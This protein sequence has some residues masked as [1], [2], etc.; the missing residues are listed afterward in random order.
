MLQPA[1]GYDPAGGVPPGCVEVSPGCVAEISPAIVVVSLENVVGASPG[2]VAEVSPAIVVAV[3]RG[4]DLVLCMH[5]L[6]AGNVA[7]AL[8]RLEHVS[9]LLPPQLSQLS[10][11]FYLP[12]GRLSHTSQWLP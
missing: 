10:F 7:R 4:Y 3:S 12:P 9:S 11:F 1:L 6:W 2:C 8:G 5:S